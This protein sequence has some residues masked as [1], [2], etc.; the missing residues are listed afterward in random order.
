MKKILVVSLLIIM[1]LISGCYGP[2][3]AVP[4]T[5]TQSTVANSVEIKGFAFNPGAITVAKGTT[6]TWT[7]EDS[8]PHTVTTT[9]APVDFDSGRMSK[10][11]TFSQTFDAAGTYEYYCSIHPNMK[12]KVIV[13]E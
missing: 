11:D 12:G 6:V 8:A 4:P 9:N 3:T 7:N 5:T 10:G 2:K 1:V 13:T